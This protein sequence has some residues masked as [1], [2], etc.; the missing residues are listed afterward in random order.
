MNK[1]ILTGLIVFLV[2]FSVSA[3]SVFGDLTGEYKVSNPTEMDSLYFMLILKEDGSVAFEAFSGD[4]KLQMECEGDGQL[5]GGMIKTQLVCQAHG[6]RALLNYD[7]DVSSVSDYENFV[8]PMTSEL[9]VMGNVRKD[10]DDGKFTK[11]Q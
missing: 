1:K 5:V 7:V 4:D 9:S 3:E 8:A 11:I 2:S 6:N 10:E